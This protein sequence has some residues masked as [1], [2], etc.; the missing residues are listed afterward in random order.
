MELKKK[1]RAIIIADLVTCPHYTIDRFKA[2]NI[3]V[4]V[5]TISTYSVPF[6]QY[7]KL[8]ILV[9]HSKQDVDADVATINALKH[10]FDFIGGIYGHDG[11]AT[12]THADKVFNQLF[13]LSANSESTSPLRYDKHALNHKLSLF[14]AGLAAITFKAATV[15]KK[16][17]QDFYAQHHGSVVLKPT[18]NSSSGK[19]VLIKPS[20]QALLTCIEQCPE[21]TFL[22]QAYIDGEEYY[23][24]TVSFNNRHKVVSI[25]RYEKNII[26]HKPVYLYSENIGK[27][28]SDAKKLAEFAIWVLE[29]SGFSTGLAHIEVKMKGAIIELI[30]LN[31]RMSG[32]YGGLNEMQLARDNHDQI[33]EFLHLAAYEQAVPIKK[34][35]LYRMVNLKNKRAEFSIPD[36]KPIYDLETVYKVNVIH[37]DHTTT[38]HRILAVVMQIFMCS[39]CHQALDVDNKC[40]LTMFN[41]FNI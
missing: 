37:N 18:K 35:L 30:E 3:N 13:P 4:V 28:S 39:D 38:N 41:Q 27:K 16:V 11:E 5:L 2:F 21:Q 22:L 34:N 19:N 26:N 29:Q 32:I 33:S 15:N 9:L 20:E 1:R 7:E 25:G 10:E 12:V 36:L 8:P 23:I 40:L 14:G 6:Y 24:D 31:A 17:L